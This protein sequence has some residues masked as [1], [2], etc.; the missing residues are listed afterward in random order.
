MGRGYIDRVDG[1][2][3]RYHAVGTGDGRTVRLR[4]NVVVD[5][6]SAVEE[7]EQM[8][9]AEADTEE[10]MAQ[11]AVDTVAESIAALAASGYRSP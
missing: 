8:E 11:I 10:D 1:P 9:P 2:P 5:I 7:P 3:G 4:V 6:V